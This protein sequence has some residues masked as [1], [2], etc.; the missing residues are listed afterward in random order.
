MIF[1]SVDSIVM[2]HE[3]KIIEYGHSYAP[4]VADMWTRSGD[5]WC[6]INI[7]K[8]VPTIQ[9]FVTGCLSTVFDFSGGTLRGSLK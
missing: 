7:E 5:S 1:V 8:S 9:R 4:A 3:F 6:G 2:K